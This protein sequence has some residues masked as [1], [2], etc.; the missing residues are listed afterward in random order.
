MQP[1]RNH[2]YF[3]H[4]DYGRVVTNDLGLIKQKQKTYIKR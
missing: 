4:L 1:K 3:V 2:C